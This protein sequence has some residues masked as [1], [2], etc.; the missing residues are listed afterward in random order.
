ME[1]AAGYTGRGAPER[2]K[3][4]SACRSS[5]LADLL[6]EL[7]AWGV[8]SAVLIQLIAQAAVVDG[9]RNERVEK[10]S[11][12]AACGDCPGNAR[13]DLFLN[14]P[15][16]QQEV[17]STEIT[18]PVQSQHAKVVNGVN[19]P[20]KTRLDMK[21]TIFLPH[22]MFRWLVANAQDFLDTVLHFK[23]SWFWANCHPEDPRLRDHPINAQPDFKNRAHPIVLHGDGAQSTDLGDSLLTLSWGFLCTLRTRLKGNKLALSIL[24]ES[25]GIKLD[26]D[27]TLCPEDCQPD[28]QLKD[29]RNKMIQEY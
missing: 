24:Q 21:H 27:W 3:T 8:I 11:K 14:S 7:Y 5:E 26:V 12:A 6:E 22:L 19:V 1:A 18:L 4:S 20:A 23:P 28:H 29:V 9:L 25:N 15:W 13:R 16:H 17:P 10:M 2:S